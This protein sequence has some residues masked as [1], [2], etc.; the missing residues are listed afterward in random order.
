[1]ADPIVSEAFYS[2]DKTVA[3]SIAG[4]AVAIVGSLWVWIRAQV[5]AQI[6]AMRAQIDHAQQQLADAI[7]RIQE[8]EDSRLAEA[9]SY[10][11]AYHEQAE[12]TVRAIERLSEAIRAMPRAVR[13]P[14]PLPEG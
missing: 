6:E 5:R 13:H 4:A 10:S 11:T 9:K 2:I 8:L 14:T 1:M 3:I 12:Q 7:K